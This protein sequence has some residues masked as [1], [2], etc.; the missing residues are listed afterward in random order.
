MTSETST[1]TSTD[2]QKTAA[3]QADSLHRRPTGSP[4]SKAEQKCRKIWLELGRLGRKNRVGAIWGFPQK[5]G[6]PSHHPF[7]D[8]IFHE[9][10]H[11]ASLGYLYFRK[12]SIWGFDKNELT[13]AARRS[14]SGR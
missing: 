2:R 10:N 9:L 6:T 8:G 11:P 1:E 4:P 7:I 12:P 3:R 5:K 14:V 13:L